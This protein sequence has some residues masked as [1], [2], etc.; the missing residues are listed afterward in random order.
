VAKVF[1]KAE[2]FQARYDPKFP[3]VRRGLEKTR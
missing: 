1:S 2:A 3:K